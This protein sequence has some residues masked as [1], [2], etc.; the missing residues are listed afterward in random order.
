MTMRPFRFAVQSV[1]QDG[2]QWLATARH[3][4]EL[5][6][7]TLLTADGLHLPS[8]LPALAMAAGATTT[9]RVGTFVLASPLRHPRLAAWD[10]HT[11]S[12]LSDGRFEF[13]VGTARPE[14]TQQAAELTGQP[15]TGA[16]RLAQAE[17]MIDE[18]AALD[19]DEHTPVLMAASG[20]KARALAAAKADIITIA[21]GHLTS[22]AEVARLTTEIREAAGDRADQLEF[23]QPIFIV[24]EEAPS[25]TRR[26][27]DADVPTLIANDSLA[28]LRGTPQQMADEL[29]RRRDELSA[30]YFSFNG[31][32]I[33]AVAPVIELLAGR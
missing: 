31:V 6:Y 13:G 14:V 11:V 12:K 22:R 30:S 24:G 23:I 3:A 8:P 2:S 19:G 15:T 9:L 17:Q 21:T 10:A 29:Q 4:E 20:P 26:F 7:S 16:E 28:I 25:W 27:L 33:D 5:G 1:A 18:L 32:F